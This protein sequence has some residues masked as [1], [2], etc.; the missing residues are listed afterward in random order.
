MLFP[1][2][3]EYG[4]MAKSPPLDATWELPIEFGEKSLYTDYS[5]SDLFCRIRAI[6]MLF[7]MNKEV[8][9]PNPQIITKIKL[10]V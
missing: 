4:I 10:A 6:H 2:S 5:K 1:L 7:F 9:L 8:R 3:Y